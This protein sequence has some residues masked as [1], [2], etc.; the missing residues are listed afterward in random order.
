MPLILLIDE[1]LIW[2][3]R[4]KEFTKVL[5]ICICRF[6]IQPTSIADPFIYNITLAMGF[7]Q[8]FNVQH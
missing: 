3:F 5:E 2:V 6:K 4:E 8:C 1:V 7:Q